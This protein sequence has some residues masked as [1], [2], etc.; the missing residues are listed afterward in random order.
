MKTKRWRFFPF[1]ESYG[2]LIYA[3]PYEWYEF[4]SDDID[5]SEEEICFN[6]QAQYFD[7][8]GKTWRK[9]NWQ[10]YRS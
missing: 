6:I 5:C 8:E 1:K 2:G 3:S 4:Y 10:D 7:E 9:I